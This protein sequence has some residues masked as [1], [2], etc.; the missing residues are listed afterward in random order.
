MM[1]EQAAYGLGPKDGWPLPKED[2]RRVSRKYVWIDFVLNII[3]IIVVIGAWV[4]VFISMQHFAWWQI[5]FPVAALLFLFSAILAFRRVRTIGFILR[6]DDLVFRRGLFF[7]RVV[8]VP[9][10]RL[11]LV[12]IHR[13]P[14]LRLFG[15]SNLKFV[16][17]AATTDV[18]LPGLPRQEAEEVRDHLI[19]VAESRRSGL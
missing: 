10:G 14:L 12:D 5:A 17:A 18:A 15:L 6:E 4:I 9:Y 2:W 3:P 7:E 1:N 8:A 19:R 16:T 13:G 11:Q